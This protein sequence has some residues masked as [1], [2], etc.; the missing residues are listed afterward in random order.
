ML[1]GERP[2]GWPAGG[3]AAAARARRASRSRCQ[4]AARSASTGVVRRGLLRR[5]PGAGQRP[6]PWS[7]WPTRGSTRP[8][9]R[10]ATASAHESTPRGRRARPPDRGRQR[11]RRPAGPLPVPGRAPPASAPGP[12]GCRGSRDLR[13]ALGPRA[14]PGRVERAAAA[15]HHQGVV[16]LPHPAALRGAWPTT[17]LPQAGARPGRGAGGCGC[18]R[19]GCARGE[20]PATLAIVL[21]E[22]PALAGWD[23]QHRRHRR[24]RGGAR[25]RP[26]RALRRARRRRRSRRPSG[27]ATSPAR[28]G[29][30]RA[31]A[32]A[33]APHRVPAPSTWSP[34]PSRCRRSPST[35]SSCATSSSTSGP[36]RSAGS[37]RRSRAPWHPTA[38]LFLGPA[39]TLWQLTE[40]LEPEDLGDCFCYRRA[41]PPARVR[42]PGSGVRGRETGER[43]EGRGER[44]RSPPTDRFPSSAGRW[45]SPGGRSRSR[46]PARGIG[47]G[48][49]LGTW[50]PVAARR[51]RASSPRQSRPTLPRHPLTPSRACST[52][53]AG[54]PDRPWPPIGPPSTWTPLCFQA[55]LLL[56]DAL[57][58]AGHHARAAQ[59]YRQVLTLL[60]GTRSR[61]LDELAPLLLPDRVTAGQRAR[62]ALAAR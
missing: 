38:I 16:L 20:E 26:P 18:G 5:G 6:T 11:Q 34:S 49:R 32:R 7:R 13:Q 35:S 52:T 8:R 59:E 62:A 25:R 29:G 2:G 36:S 50:R 44:G 56:A 41:G 58:R 55:R 30:L 39:E 46:G 54:G 4:R 27:R 42:G 24:R 60:A 43:A 12:P 37:W 31:V 14:A 57:R 21:A 33:A 1:T 48:W 51:R 40:E 15:H 19:P 53:S 22:S 61:E 10:G 47:W 45:M 3:G 9:P 23:W 28:G 17:L